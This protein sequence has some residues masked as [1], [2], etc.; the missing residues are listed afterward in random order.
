MS[1]AVVSSRPAIMRSRVDLP[2]P[3]GPTK[4]T[5]SF[6]ST[7][8][9]MP[10]MTLVSPNAFSTFDR[11]SSLNR[12]SLGGPAEASVDLGVPAD[13]PPA[14]GRWTWNGYPR[15]ERLLLERLDVG[16]GLGQRSLRLSLASHDRLHHGD[17]GV[18]HALVVLE[19]RLGSTVADAVEE[20]LPARVF[21]DEVS[22]TRDRTE[23]RQAVRLLVGE[24]V[25]VVGQELGEIHRLVFHTGAL[26][27]GKAI[28]DQ[29][30]ARAYRRRT[31]RETDSN[32]HLTLQT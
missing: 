26:E 4:T 23:R 1:P 22:Y 18:L 3:E 25:L 27:D 21:L 15:P 31:S 30:R 11:V 13:E 17:E 5:N 9:S 24:L 16:G 29:Q 19:Q 28:G 8:R 6:G 20:R 10:L 12:Y 2:Q 7:S 14:P 32:K